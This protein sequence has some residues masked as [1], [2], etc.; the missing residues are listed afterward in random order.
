MLG[1]VLDCLELVDVGRR[2]SHGAVWGRGNH[3]FDR[4]PRKFLDLDTSLT[5]T[6]FSVGTEERDT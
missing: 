5:R 1:V 4:S 3:W 6:R 2:H